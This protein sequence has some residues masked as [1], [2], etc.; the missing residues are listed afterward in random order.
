MPNLFCRFG[1]IFINK[2]FSTVFEINNT[3]LKIF[4]KKIAHFLKNKFLK[5]EFIF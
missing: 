5:S 2:I 3:F 1:I 4:F